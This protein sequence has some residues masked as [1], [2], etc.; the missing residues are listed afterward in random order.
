MGIAFFQVTKYIHPPEAAWQSGGSPVS[1]AG[2]P[3]LN[4][5]PLVI[6]GEQLNLFKAQFPHL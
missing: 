2:G 1:E 3:P 6:L 5:T 4:L